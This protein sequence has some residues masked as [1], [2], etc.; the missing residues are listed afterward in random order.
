MNDLAI[1]SLRF[2]LVT[3]QQ[4]WPVTR[5]NIRGEMG[6]PMRARARTRA[7]ATFQSP[8]FLGPEIEEGAVN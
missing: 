5:T 7:R 8:V 6:K 1:C 3:L 4:K 2:V